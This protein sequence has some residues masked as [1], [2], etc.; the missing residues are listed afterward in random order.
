[1][2]KYNQKGDKIMKLKKMTFLLS[3]SMLLVACGNDEATGEES[4]EQEAGSHDESSDQEVDTQEGGTISLSSALETH[5][6]WFRVN[7]YPERS[8]E[9]N[10]IHYYNDGEITVYRLDNS[11]FIPSEFGESVTLERILDY[12]DK[13]IIDMFQT[14]YQEFVEGGIAESFEA[15][16]QERKEEIE[17]EIESIDNDSTSSTGVWWT[18]EKQKNSL[19]FEIGVR[20]VFLESFNKEYKSDE[21][22]ALSDHSTEYTI[23][24]TLDGTGNNVESQKITY[25]L[26][27][28]LSSNKE[29]NFSLDLGS[30]YSN[31]SFPR[32]TDSEY[33]AD[34]LDNAEK[35]IEEY[36][37]RLT[38]PVPDVT[39]TLRFSS[40]GNFEIFDTVFSGYMINQEFRYY[41]TRIENESTEFILDDTD[42]SHPNVTI[43][44]EPSQ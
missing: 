1:M 44:G 34:D 15:Q 37:S 3:A 35:S 6:V 24:I 18:P 13:E 29:K 17:R 30:I 19:E 21:F 39:T 23:D 7:D 20:D 27:S 2:A 36:I 32:A 42:V 41:I 4:S 38:Q 22:K 25:D 5:P 43:E 14:S 11:E 40:G 28:F 8:T 31:L 16:V 33:T 26:P 10:S 12:S 9:I